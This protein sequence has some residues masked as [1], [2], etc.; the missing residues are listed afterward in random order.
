MTKT[1]K[2]CSKG[3]SFDDCELAILRM[4][5]DKAQEKVAKRAVASPAIKDMMRIVEDFIRKRNLIPYGGIAI[6]NILPILQRRNRYTRL[7]FLFPQCHG[8]R[9]EACRYLP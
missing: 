6:N 5:V 3:A 4:A 9:Q 2:I 8:R 1:K 7:R